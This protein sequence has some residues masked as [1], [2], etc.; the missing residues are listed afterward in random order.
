[1]LSA[2]VAVDSLVGGGSASG[3]AGDP[4]FLVFWALPFAA[5]AVFLG[6]YA[7]R[8]D[9]REV[10]DAARH[11]CVGSLV[12]GGGVLLF[13]LARPLLLSGDVLNG[14]VTALL[15]APLAAIVGFLIGV[16]SLRMR[17]RRP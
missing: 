10:R 2:W 16:G 8:G 4:S 15:Y 6:W 1:M 11:G 3:A 14:A 12:L 7:L 13:L 5:A 9:R 17:K